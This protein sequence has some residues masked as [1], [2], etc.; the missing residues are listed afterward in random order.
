MD[1][2]ILVREIRG[3]FSPNNYTPHS[4]GINFVNLGISSRWVQKNSI[5]LIKF[6][7]HYA[8]EHQFVRRNAFILQMI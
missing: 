8:N 7:F 3:K 5:Y 2:N 6:I 4:L 1:W